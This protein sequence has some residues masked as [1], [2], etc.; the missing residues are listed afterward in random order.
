MGT[1]GGIPPPQEIIT[2]LLSSSD[3][4]SERARKGGMKLLWD[5][6]IAKVLGGLTTFEE[7]KRA[8]LAQEQG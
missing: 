3:V 2:R 7:V 6:G 4:I 8:A 5:A 1:F